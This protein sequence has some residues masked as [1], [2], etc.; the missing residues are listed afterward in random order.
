MDQ[1]SLE[2][3]TAFEPNHLLAHGTTGENSD[4]LLQ[5]SAAT[6]IYNPNG[7]ISGRAQ[8]GPSGDIPTPDGHTVIYTPP[9]TV[10]APGRTGEPSTAQPAAPSWSPAPD[11]MPGA[12]QPTVGAPGYGSFS[13][14]R[15]LTGTDGGSNISQE[16]LQQMMHSLH[17]DFNPDTYYGLYPQ[18]ILYPIPTPFGAVGGAWLG[19]GFAPYRMDN[20]FAQPID[21]DEFLKK[22]DADLKAMGSSGDQLIK[23]RDQ[24]KAMKKRGAPYVEERQVLRQI[25]MLYGPGGRVGNWWRKYH[26]PYLAQLDLMRTKIDSDDNARTKLLKALNGDPSDKENKGAEERFK[27]AQANEH[28]WNKLLT[29]SKEP[30]TWDFKVE[31]KWNEWAQEKLDHGVS[32]VDLGKEGGLLGKT[33][34][35]VRRLQEV[36]RL[37]ANGELDEATA[38]FAKFDPALQ[39]QLRS[40]HSTPTEP[41]TADVLLKATN[42]QLKGTQWGDRLI[43]LR[44]EL[45]TLRASGAPDADQQAVLDRANSIYRMPP[46]AADDV[47]PLQKKKAFLADLDTDLSS[48]SDIDA[49]KAKIRSKVIGPDTEYGV[50][51]FLTRQ[52]AELVLGDGTEGNGLVPARQASWDAES[53]RNGLVK[54]IATRDDAIQR[55]QKA[56][57]E[58]WGRRD[59]EW[60][61]KEQP[62]V[63]TNG[64]YGSVDTEAPAVSTGPRYF[65][66]GSGRGDEFNKVTAGWEPLDSY[67]Q[68]HKPT[69]TFD[70][71]RLDWSG[72]NMWRRG[73]EALGITA[74]GIGLDALG[75][76]LIPGNSGSPIDKTRWV[77]TAEGPLAAMALLHGDPGITPTKLF[78]FGAAVWAPKLADKYLIHSAPPPAFTDIMKPTWEQGFTMALGWALPFRAEEKYARVGAVLG[79]WALGGPVLNSAV[80]GIEHFIPG[81]QKLDPA[82]KWLGLGSSQGAT[83]LYNAVTSDVHSYESGRSAAGFQNIERDSTTLANENWAGLDTIM[84]LFT[85]DHKDKNDLSSPPNLETMAALWSGRADMWLNKGTDVEPQGSKAQWP[86]RMLAGMGL[87][88]GGQA[89]GLFAGGQNVDNNGYV[90]AAS[91]L[92]AAAQG[93]KQ[94]GANADATRAEQ[95][96]QMVKNKIAQICESHHDIQSAFNR[97]LQAAGPQVG[98]GEAAVPIDKFETFVNTV[99]DDVRNHMNDANLAPQLKAKLYRDLALLD[100]V[101]AA[102]HAQSRGTTAGGFDASQYLQEAQQVIA[103]ARQLDSQAQDQAQIENL[104][105]SLGPTVAAAGNTQR[106]SPIGSPFGAQ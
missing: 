70:K 31:D 19:S 30:E 6:I 88:L 73:G 20:K 47:P 56:L 42:K 43:E 89:L 86:Q 80:Y 63:R 66:K 44:D 27:E 85:Q 84:A 36:N 76:T 4:A 57:T 58:L 53:V 28:K 22:S 10:I 38:L 94:G 97:L 67:Y 3:T 14:N 100:A 61:T 96:S 9:N 60:N 26:S 103:A 91:A 5:L 18:A 37:L 81:G 15:G 79:G 51:H 77:Q 45:K 7:T 8:Y 52:D 29:G 49:I 90:Q 68:T 24:L 34:L 11:Q 75:D 78:M 21:Y 48:T 64:F 99:R 32:D 87:D 106:T 65:F 39:T 40:Q 54:D 101:E 83:P 35:Q 98:N 55:Q 1:P 33:I 46:L 72:D 82:F 69:S 13:W 59:F 71:L 50:D 25:D 41:L 102:W 104:I 62:R 93:Y 17:G 95:E 105:Q 23:L 74:L 92:D 2:K 16:Q 12:Q